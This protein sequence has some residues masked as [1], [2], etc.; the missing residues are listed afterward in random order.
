MSHLPVRST[1][2]PTGH[3][4]LFVWC[5]CPTLAIMEKDGTQLMGSRQSAVHKD[6]EAMKSSSLLPA[7][8]PDGNFW[9]SL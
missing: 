3:G 6:P 2:Y 8:S 9:L 7:Y 1:R 4:L 5:P